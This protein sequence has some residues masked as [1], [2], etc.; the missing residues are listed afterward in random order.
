MGYGGIFLSESRFKPDT[1]FKFMAI[2]TGFIE[3]LL[4]RRVELWVLFLVMLLGLIAS[5]ALAWAVRHQT[6][7]GSRL[8]AMGSVVIRVASSPSDVKRA[9]LGVLGLLSGKQ[10]ELQSPEDRFRDRSGFEFNSVP[11]YRPDDGYL[12]LNRYDGD[13][14]HSVSELWDLRSH[15]KI[16]T[17]SFAAVDELW[18]NSNLKT[19]FNV[20]VDASSRRFRGTHALLSDNGD[21]IT[22]DLYTPLIRASVCSQLEFFQQDAVYHHSIERDVDG[23]YWSPT[24]IEPSSA[25]IGGEFFLDDGL[26]QISPDGVVLRKKSIVQILTENGLAALVYGSG[27]HQEDDP[28]HLNDIQPVTEDGRHWKKGDVFLSLRHQSM[29]M[30]YR[31]SIDKVLW[32]K[33]GP[34]VHQH[35]V[36]ILNDHQ[37][38]VFNNNAYRKGPNNSAVRD[39]NDIMVYDFDTGV[40]DSPWERGFKNLELR[41]ISEGRGER[42]GSDVVV[43]ESNYGRI[44]QFDASGKVTWEFINRAADNRIYRLNWSRMVTRELGDKVRTVVSEV[45]CD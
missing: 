1:R 39:F 41:T 9:I 11:G 30:L 38:S 29:V 14:S 12:L 42:V 27:T 23:N 5:I 21:L 10:P 3:R 45:V 2:R 44:V 18:R 7:G 19:R 33:Q 32:F 28:I 26:S 15:E 16:W 40:V 13:R 43:E 36:N 35:D 34:W 6:T 22:K 24:V 4:F 8:G 37:I 31:P 17:W 20:K 25:G